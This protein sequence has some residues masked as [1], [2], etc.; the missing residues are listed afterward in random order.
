[1][2]APPNPTDQQPE[3]RAIAGAALRL[4]SMAAISAMLALVK[5][6]Q[7]RGVSIFES[8]FYRQLFAVPA[9]LLAAMFV[10]F[11]IQVFMRYVVDRPVGWTVEALGRPPMR[12]MQ[13]LTRVFVTYIGVTAFSEDAPVTSLRRNLTLITMVDSDGDGQI[14]LDEFMAAA[15]AQ[16]VKSGEDAGA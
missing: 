8:V 6:A 10:C 4:V 3:Q 15:L 13:V 16:R 11:I 1:M 5:L 2:N 12:R 14:S 7:T 9:I